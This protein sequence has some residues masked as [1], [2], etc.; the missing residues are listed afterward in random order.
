LAN[1]LIGLEVLNRA[2]Q[3]NGVG[4]YLDKGLTI[5]VHLEISGI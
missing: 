2:K 5:K 1:Q 3:E 4:Y